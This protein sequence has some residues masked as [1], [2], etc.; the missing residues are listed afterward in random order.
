M[1]RRWAPL[2][3]TTGGARGHHDLGQCSVRSGV[4]SHERG[5]GP[6]AHHSRSAGR[7]VHKERA[8]AKEATEGG[9]RDQFRMCEQ[10]D[11]SV[12]SKRTVLVQQRQRRRRRRLP[13]HLE[14]PAPVSSQCVPRPTA[15]WLWPTAGGASLP[16][17]LLLPSDWNADVMAGSQQSLWLNTHNKIYHLNHFKWTVSHKTE[18]WFN[19]VTSNSL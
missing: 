11:V 5:W 10:T 13:A 1:D 19:S 9:W 14:T 6:G 17:S 2:R 12:S 18:V 8:Q 7:W 15:A 4:G 3:L 16:S